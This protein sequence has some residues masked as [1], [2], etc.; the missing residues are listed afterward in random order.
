[1]SPVRH[2][3]EDLDDLIADITVDCYDD[4][5]A[6]MGFEVAFDDQVSF[7]VS[8]AVIG[9]HVQVLS[10]GR[11]DGRRELVATCERE[12]RRYHVERA[13]LLKMRPVGR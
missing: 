13:S 3:A 7:P 4:D 1:M 8:G 12:S 11:G 6:L 5:E 2:R 9:E 10:V